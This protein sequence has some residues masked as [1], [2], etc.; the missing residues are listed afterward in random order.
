MDNL[1]KQVQKIRLTVFSILVLSLAF[2]P[3]FK[4]LAVE[5]KNFQSQGKELQ[6]VYYVPITSQQSPQVLGE[7]TSVLNEFALNNY[8]QAI[9]KLTDLQEVVTLTSGFN[10]G[11]VTA[12]SS[13]KSLNDL[14][15]Q[16]EKKYS[17]GSSFSTKTIF[18]DISILLNKISADKLGGQ[19]ISGQYKVQL[20]SLAEKLENQVINLLIEDE[21][22]FPTV[23]F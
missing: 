10:Q 17:T 5:S 2:L 13:K 16:L 3:T 8:N 15:L 20:N 14:V 4:V 6:S 21:K 7:S 1:T 12:A 11:M 9:F 23:G 19:E 18:T 22:N